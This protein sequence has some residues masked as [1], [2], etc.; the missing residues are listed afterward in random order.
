MYRIR[1]RR[2]EENR[3]RELKAR[4]HIKMAYYY[5]MKNKRKI[6]QKKKKRNQLVC[7]DLGKSYHDQSMA[8]QQNHQYEHEQEWWG[9]HQSDQE[10]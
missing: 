3:Q 2:S 9:A 5:M 1:R 4:K 6:K 8:R 10:T 7:H